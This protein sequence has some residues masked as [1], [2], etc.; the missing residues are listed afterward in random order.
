MKFYQTNFMNDCEGCPLQKKC[1]L[2][3]LRN[4]IV[5]G[6]G[7]THLPGGFLYNPTNGEILNVDGTGPSALQID[8]HDIVTC[9]G[10]DGSPLNQSLI[11]PIEQMDFP[12]Y[13][14]SNPEAALG[15]Y[16]RSVNWVYPR[17]S[18]GSLPLAA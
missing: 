2:S 4:K 7:V 11:Y 5:R 1:Q 13:A 6:F 17:S 16:G 9:F 14:K 8:K 12:N 10:S 18:Y 15:R 3:P